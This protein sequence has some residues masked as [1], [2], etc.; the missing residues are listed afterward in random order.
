MGVEGPWFG[1]KC[2]ESVQKTCAKKNEQNPQ[3]E[4][5]PSQE[6][7]GAGVDASEKARVLNLDKMR[8][9]SC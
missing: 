7:A 5:N 3:P 1:R 6:P 9:D 8:R 4:K 2:Q